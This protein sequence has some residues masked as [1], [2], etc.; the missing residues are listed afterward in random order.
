MPN[1]SFLMYTNL[2]VIEIKKAKTNLISY[3]QIPAK[4]VDSVFFKEYQEYQYKQ[5]CSISNR[6]SLRFES[7]VYNDTIFIVKPCLVCSDLFSDECYVFKKKFV[8]FLNRNKM[9]PFS[10]KR[11]Q[12]NSGN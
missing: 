6:D 2:S 9:L 10:L 7:F 1:Q 12:E 11:Q 8:Q 5:S 3:Y 4:E